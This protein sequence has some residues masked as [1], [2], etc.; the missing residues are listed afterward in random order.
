MA[1]QDFTNEDFIPEEQ[2]GVVLRAVSANSAVER[3]ARRVLMNSNVRDIPTLD[4]ADPR[5]VA[6]HA[7]YPEADLETGEYV[8]RAYKFG[9]ILHVSEEDLADSFVNVIDEY[10][11]NW[12]SNWAV[13]YDN[14]C[15]GTVGAAGANDTDRALRPFTSVYQAA[16]V[17]GN[18]TP[19][20]GDLTLNQLSGSLGALEESNFWTPQGNVIIAHPTLRGALRTLKDEAGNLVMERGDS[21]T[22]GVGDRLFG[23]EV[24]FSLG[25]RTS[26][27]MTSSPTG[28]KL[29]VMGSKNHLLNGVRSG[30]ESKLGEQFNTDGV[31]IKVRA[32]RAFTVANPEAVQVIEITAGP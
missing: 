14:A 21:L 2:D 9:E 29:I 12:F 11:V 5:Y 20:A 30:P 19:T 26:T 24:H 13:K 17:A 28:N 23:Y 6:E 22:G 32:R 31:L 7:A 25:A 3:A 8:L 27:S 18:V 16:T 10:K 15:L 1:V 4:G